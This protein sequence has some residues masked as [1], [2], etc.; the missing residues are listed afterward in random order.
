MNSKRRSSR[1]DPLGI[2]NELKQGPTASAD[3]QPARA[4]HGAP[5]SNRPSFCVT[6]ISR[7]PGSDDARGV[8]ERLFDVGDEVRGRLRAKTSRGGGDRRRR[9]AHRKRDARARTYAEARTEETAREHAARGVVNPW[10]RRGEGETDHRARDSAPG[11]FDARRSLRV[12]SAAYASQPSSSRLLGKQHFRWRA[13]GGILR[14]REREHARAR[15]NDRGAPVSQPT[16][17]AA[18]TGAPPRPR[19]LRTARR[20]SRAVVPSPLIASRVASR[21]DAP[22]ARRRRARGRAASRSRR[23][24][25]SRSS[26]GARGGASP[27]AR[28]IQGSG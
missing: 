4:P 18:A 28:V 16:T 24:P 22:R 17:R 20:L 27:R 9:A 14:A 1:E 19:R 8:I 7:R 10:W 21:R 25:P 5:V 13:P 3:G 2:Q 11:A 12:R 26:G 6:I 15:K 23:R